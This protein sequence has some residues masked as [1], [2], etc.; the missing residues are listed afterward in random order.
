MLDA[1]TPACA[2]TYISGVRSRGCAAATI[3]IASNSISDMWR[4][5]LI[6]G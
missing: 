5:Y 3:P 2:P 6:D 1:I 4:R